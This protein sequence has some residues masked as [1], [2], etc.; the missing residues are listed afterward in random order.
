M[1]LLESPEW[2]SEW[3]SDW[4]LNEGDLE[5]FTP[6]LQEILNFWVFYAI[7]NSIKLPKR[8]LQGKNYLG[9]QFTLGANGTSYTSVYKINKGCVTLIVAFPFTLKSILR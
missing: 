2:V 7:E 1:V 6:K 3:V 4:D 9:N 8:V 5:I